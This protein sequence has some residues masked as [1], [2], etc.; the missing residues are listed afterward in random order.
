M[1]KITKNMENFPSRR[2]YPMHEVCFKLNELPLFITAGSITAKNDFIHQDR[3]MQEHVFI[4][5]YQGEMEI[6]E[7]DITYHLLPGEC[8]FLKAGIHHWGKKVIRAG[9]SWFYVH[10]SLSDNIDGFRSYDDNIVAVKQQS[11]EPDDFSC[12]LTLPKHAA[13]PSHSRI[14]RRVRELLD[15]YVS[16]DPLRIV[17]INAALSELLADFYQTV[18]R[19][20]RVDKAELIVRKLIEFLEQHNTESITSEVIAQHMRLSYKYLCT[21]FRQKT[22]LSINQYHTRL[23]INE[24]AR[25]LR[26]T[27]LN[28]SEASYAVGYKDPLYFSSVFKR[29]YGKPPIE[30]L[31]ETFNKS[32]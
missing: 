11:F 15:L 3:I 4:Y 2:K 32:N 14:D 9:T 18:I 28:V 20:Q 16:S 6:I 17:H 8:L 1:S 22:G 12:Y 29:I 26:E 27:S 7:D 25:I 23:R 19:E 24:A 30:Y 13:L 10:V 31:K 5:L 21:D